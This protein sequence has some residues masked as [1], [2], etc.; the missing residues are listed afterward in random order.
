M[1]SSY[2]V[3]IKEIMTF[4]DTGLNISNTIIFY[5]NDLRLECN[6]FHSGLVPEMIVFINLRNGY[7]FRKRGGPVNC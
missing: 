2:V 6:V 3:S 7:R 4:K 1:I 5:Q